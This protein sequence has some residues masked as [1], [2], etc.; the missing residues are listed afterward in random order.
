MNICFQ[1]D[2]PWIRQRHWN[3]LSFCFWTFLGHKIVYGLPGCYLRV[4]CKFVRCMLFWDYVPVMRLVHTSHYVLW[5]LYCVVRL[6]CLVHCYCNVVVIL[7]DFSSAQCISFWFNKFLFPFRK[8][9]CIIFLNR[10]SWFL[11]GR[12]L[13][14]YDNSWL[15]LKWVNY[16]RVRSCLAHSLRILNGWDAN[17]RYVI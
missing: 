17:C 9:I 1:K 15:Y 12:V 8:K 10:L 11:F 14:K 5:C 2:Q 16:M 4:Y 3:I 6:E 7:V 13:M